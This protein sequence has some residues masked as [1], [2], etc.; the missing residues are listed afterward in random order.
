[1]CVLFV[2]GRGVCA[3]VRRCHIDPPIH[4]IAAT[5]GKKEKL[6]QLRNGMVVGEARVQHGCQR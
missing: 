5:T 4:T 2:R 3:C 1:M 6:T